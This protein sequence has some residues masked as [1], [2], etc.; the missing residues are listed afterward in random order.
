M[1][2]GTGSAEPRFDEAFEE[3]AEGLVLLLANSLRWLAMHPRSSAM[4]LIE[5]FVRDGELTLVVDMPRQ[6]ALDPCKSLRP[7]GQ[8]MGWLGK[9]FLN[10]MPF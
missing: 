5:G 6:S 2:T 10:F 4:L 9:L 7:N 8:E 1:K 3:I